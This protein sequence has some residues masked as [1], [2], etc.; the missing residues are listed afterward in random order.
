MIQ[1]NT[2]LF[3][4]TLYII[5]YTLHIHITGTCRTGG[6]DHYSP[7]FTHMKWNVF[8]FNLWKIINVLYIYLECQQKSNT[9]RVIAIEY[10]TYSIIC[11]HFERLTQRGKQN[12]CIMYII[13][14]CQFKYYYEYTM[15][16][17][18]TRTCFYWLF[19]KGSITKK[20]YSFWQLKKW[21]MCGISKAFISICVYQ[22]IYN[23]VT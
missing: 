16:N 1:E 20:E 8:M 13:L 6:T 7:L 14:N 17:T 3:W 18:L 15:L 23:I 4:N 2:P 21:D 9:L 19:R 12:V 22:A 11:S 5:S 10:C